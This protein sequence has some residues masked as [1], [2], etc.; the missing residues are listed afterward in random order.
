MRRNMNCSRPSGCKHATK[1]KTREFYCSCSSSTSP[2]MV[3]TFLNRLVSFRSRLYL[4]VK[5]SFN[6]CSRILSLI[7]YSTINCRFKWVTAALTVSPEWLADPIIIIDSGHFKITSKMSI[8]ACVI[9][10][11]C[12]RGRVL[13]VQQTPLLT[14]AL[15]RHDA[16]SVEMHWAHSF[17]PKREHSVLCTDRPSVSSWSVWASVIWDSFPPKARYSVHHVYVLNCGFKWN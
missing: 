11:P 14:F 17:T 5:N 2:V 4:N 6:M 13:M 3:L 12:S 9:I 8:K 1:S 10:L 16:L 15:G 7:Y